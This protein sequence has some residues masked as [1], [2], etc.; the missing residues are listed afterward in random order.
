MCV[1]TMAVS[2]CDGTVSV[3]EKVKASMW[4]DERRAAQ[5]ERA[6]AQWTDDKKRLSRT[7]L[8]VMIKRHERQREGRS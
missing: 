5:A 3:S 6:R 2:V 4:T 8:E 7:Y 1:V